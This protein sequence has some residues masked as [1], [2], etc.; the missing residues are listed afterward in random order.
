MW[1][2]K[3]KSE[4]NTILE[5][6][7]W[8]YKRIITGYK[9]ENLIVLFT[10]KMYLMPKHL[11]SV[12]VLFNRQSFCFSL[13]MLY[14]I[15]IS[16][17]DEMYATFINHTIFRLHRIHSSSIVGQNAALTAVSSRFDNQSAAFLSK[18]VSPTTSSY[19]Y[20]IY[21]ITVVVFKIWKTYLCWQTSIFSQEV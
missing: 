21:T 10:N 18:L 19:Q 3:V 4:W 5:I 15:T 16:V 8:Y 6:P 11:H 7:F 1:V 14:C 13:Q 2:C 17:I 9:L 20:C 12:S